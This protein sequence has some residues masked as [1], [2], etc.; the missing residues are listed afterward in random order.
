MLE[1]GIE[2]LFTVATPLNRRVNE[3]VKHTER[4]HF[5]DGTAAVADVQRFVAHLEEAN[6]FVLLASDVQSVPV[7]AHFTD[8]S[9]RMGQVLGLE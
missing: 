5:N 4:F 6:A 3:E 2:Q 8:R 7:C 1:H 9:D